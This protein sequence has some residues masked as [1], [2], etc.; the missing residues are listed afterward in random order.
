MMAVEGI[1]YLTQNLADQL[2]GQPLIST[3]EA[4]TQGAANAGAAAVA[5]DTFTPSSQNNSAQATAQDAGIFQLSQEALV[6][7]TASVLFAQASPNTNLDGVLAQPASATATN[8]GNAQPATP[9]NSNASVNQG[10]LFGPAPAGQAPPVKATPATN[11]QEEVLVLNAQ[12]PALGLSKVEIQEIDNIAT[13]LQNFNPSAYANLINQFETL[14]QQATQP[15]APNLPG[16]ANTGS[17]NS[18]PNTKVIGNGSQ[19]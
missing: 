16:N 2:A 7:V 9:A 8:T 14:A 4:N 17:Q 3:A 1:G 13:Q 5:V 15:G 11:V 12:L 6:G 18:A 19:G 10:Q